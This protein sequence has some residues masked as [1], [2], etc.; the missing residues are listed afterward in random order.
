MSKDWQLI[1]IGLAIGVATHVAGCDPCYEEPQK[2]LTVGNYLV[3]EQFL[4]DPGDTLF[5]GARVPNLK[6]A[7]L[8]VTG[9]HQMELRYLAAT[10]QEVVV[11]FG[12]GNIWDAAEGGNGGGGGSSGEGGL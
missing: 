10:G 12:P 3:T 4:L 1:A 11:E 2:P 7:T 8:N 6:G 9:L 5:D